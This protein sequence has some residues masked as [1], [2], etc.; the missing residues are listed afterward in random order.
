M[1]SVC[2]PPDEIRALAIRALCPDRAGTCVCCDVSGVALAQPTTKTSHRP[3]LRSY[4]QDRSAGANVRGESSA[5]AVETSR[6][7]R[8]ASSNASRSAASRF[9][10]SSSHALRSANGITSWRC[11]YANGS[12]HSSYLLVT[13][14]DAAGIGGSGV[15]AHRRAT[16]IV[17]GVGELV[18]DHDVAA[19]GCLAPP[20]L[21]LDPACAD[22]DARFYQ[23]RSGGR[24]RR[25][26]RRSGASTDEDE[27]ES[28]SSILLLLRPVARATDLG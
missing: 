14:R 7:V 6:H 12:D 16:Y 27:A 17:S 10:R 21:D 22:D 20:D 11:E 13:R 4:S 19:L 9:A 3:T 24:R 5:H 15:A 23:R 28:H 8:S 18:G 2:A 25:S 26:R 1:S